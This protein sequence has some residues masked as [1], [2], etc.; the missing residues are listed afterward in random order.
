MGRHELASFVGEYAEDL[1]TIRHR[2]RQPYQAD[3]DPATTTAA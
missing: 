1:R 3:H 2:A